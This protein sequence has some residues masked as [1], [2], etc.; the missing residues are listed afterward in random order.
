MSTLIYYSMNHFIKLTSMVINKLH[1]TQIIK[2]ESKYYINMTCNN[3]N[4]CMILSS[5]SISS[6]CDMIEICETKNKKDYDIIT[7]FIE[8][9]K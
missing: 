3:I 8:N 4:G 1:I 6:N 5:G 2:C 7:D 9:I